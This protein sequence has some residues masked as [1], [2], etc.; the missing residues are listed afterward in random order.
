MP[1]QTKTPSTER[2]RREHLAGRQV[3]PVA[4]VDEPLR[5]DPVQR[6]IEGRVA[7]RC[8]TASRRAGVDACG[9]RSQSLVL[10]AIDQPVVGAHALLH[11]LRRHADHVRVADPRGARRPT[12]IAMRA[13]SSPCCGCTH[14]MPAS[15]CSSASS[16]SARRGGQ[17]ARRHLLDQHAVPPARRRRRARPRGW[18]RLRGS[19]RRRS[20]RR[21]RPA[22]SRGR[23]RRRCAR[24]AAAS[25]GRRT[26]VRTTCS[27]CCD[28]RFSCL[29][30]LTTTKAGTWPPPDVTLASPVALSRVRKPATRPR[31]RYGREIDEHVAHRD[32]AAPRRR[33]TPRAGRR[34]APARPSRD[35]ARRTARVDR[36]VPC[37]LAGLPAERHAGAAVLVVRLDARTGSRCARRCASRSIVLPS[38]TTGPS[39]TI[40]RPRDVSPDDLALLGV[41]R[42]A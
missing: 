28:H 3:R 41:N 33:E 12:T 9:I 14:R 38:R 22:G 34:S 11:D 7:T 17:R 26:V 27:T 29:P 35:R 32:A 10:S 23:P 25:S 4:P 30:R 20:A 2:R 36:V 24:P 1:S 5:L 19:P 18:R 39:S 21:A 15:A 42:C 8:R 13:P 16:T 40:A 31:N 37:R 6:R